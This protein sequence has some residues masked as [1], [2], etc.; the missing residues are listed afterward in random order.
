MIEPV[1]VIAGAT[2]PAAGRSLTRLA[3]E[4]LM[5]NR[6]AVVSIVVL[7]LVSG[8]YIFGPFFTPHTYDQVFESY[9]RTPP[10]L[11]PYPRAE[12]LQ[13]VMASAAQQARVTLADFSVEGQ[14]FHATFTSP[15]KIDPRVTRY[16]D[17]TDEFDAT[18]V[19]ETN[20]DGKT[21]VVTG[22]VHREYFLMGTDSNGRDLFE[23]IMIGGRISLLVGVLATLVSPSS[24]SPMAPFPAS[25]AA[26]STTP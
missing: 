9:V 15:T 10:S 21:L 1:E 16:V 14:T 3:L 26:A 12:T 7:A 13:Q 19:T 25:P 18:A 4:R 17:R 22:A 8:L 2:T 24:A 5:R 20:D 6:A 11:E 23:R